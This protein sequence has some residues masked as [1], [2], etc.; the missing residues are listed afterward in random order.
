M[1]NCIS[2]Q[3]ESDTYLFEKEILSIFF[4]SWSPWSVALKTRI[5]SIV[6][7]SAKQTKKKRLLSLEVGSFRDFAVLIDFFS[8]TLIMTLMTFSSDFANYYPQCVTEKLQLFALFILRR[9]AWKF[10]F[11]WN[12]IITALDGK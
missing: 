7:C 3:F 12:R 5:S 2:I 9:M 11:P 8:I 10:I 1:F 4:L 6:I